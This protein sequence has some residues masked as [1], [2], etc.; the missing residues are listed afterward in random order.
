MVRSLNKWL[1]ITLVGYVSGIMVTAH[2]IGIRETPR[3]IHPLHIST[4]EINHNAKDRTLEISC[5]IFTDDFET[6][7]SKLFKT[8]AD[9]SSASL[10]Q[11]MDTLVKK[12]VIGKLQIKADDRS[13][14]LQYVGF[15]K[16]DQAIYAYFQVDNITSVRKIDVTD[17]ILHDLYDDQIE[18]IH[19]VVGGNRKSTKL[20]YPAKQASF[21][22]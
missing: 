16:E 20:D 22:F 5:H 12:Y 15:E 6:V 9:L 4:V 2:P 13:T 8:K 18:I 21:S 10:K 11:Q 14:S 3:P 7:L 19:V 1:S 17:S